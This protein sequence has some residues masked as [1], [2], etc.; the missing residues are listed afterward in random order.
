MLVASFRWR[1]A[2][3]AKVLAFAVQ[4]RSLTFDPPAGF[5]CSLITLSD[6]GSHIPYVGRWRAMLKFR[7]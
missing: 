1:Q 7:V 5:F 4:A 3:G 6:S 2:Y